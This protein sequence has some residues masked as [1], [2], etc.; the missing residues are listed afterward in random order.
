MTSIQDI[1][2]RSYGIIGGWSEWVRMGEMAGTMDT[3][4]GLTC[5]QIV[6]MGVGSLITQ[7]FLEGSGWMSPV[8]NEETCGDLEHIKKINAIRI[9]LVDAPGYHVFYR[10]CMSNGSWSDW[11]RDF[12][13]AGDTDGGL[14]MIGFEFQVAMD[15]P[16]LLYRGY[17]QN[18]GWTSFVGDNQVVGME[19]KGLRLEALYIHYG[20]P[21]KLV[22]QAN[23]ENKGWLD[24][25]SNDVVCGTERQGLRMES[26][27]IR[28]L[29]VEGYHVFYR[30][31]V[32]GL[33]WQPWMK[34]GED[35]GSEGSG[36]AIEAIR[37][38]IA[39]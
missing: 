6:S 38:R 31:C 4:N 26:I 21:G 29:N 7:C 11:R 3:Q 8:I 36:Q 37:I 28:L 23:V 2:Y 22:M 17:V 16:H 14:F 30:V 33:G 19:G 32:K 24:E 35:A 12:D 25:V 10:V 5:F 1:R 34:D 27:R 20:G 18:I 13:I 39:M 9:R 15:E